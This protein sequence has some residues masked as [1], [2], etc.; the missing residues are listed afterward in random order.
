M[1]SIVSPVR[2]LGSSAVSLVVGLVVVVLLSVD[3]SGLVGL[4]VCCSFSL[5]V[6]FGRIRP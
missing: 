5:V 6:V 1:A 4:S 2:T 3:N